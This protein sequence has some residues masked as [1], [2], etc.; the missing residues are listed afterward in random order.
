[1]NMDEQVKKLAYS[2]WES[3]ARPE[4]KALEHYYRA[5]KILREQESKRLQPTGFVS[6]S[7]KKRS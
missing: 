2:I 4:A 1:M 7:S 6:T 5:E 3:E